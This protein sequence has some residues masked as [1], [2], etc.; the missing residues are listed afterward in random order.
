LQQIFEGVELG[1]RARWGVITSGRSTATDARGMTL[2][3][4]MNTPG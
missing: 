1:L 2:R 4:L 3:D